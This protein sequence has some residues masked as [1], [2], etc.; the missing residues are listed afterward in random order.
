MFRTLRPD[1]IE[2]RIG[3]VHKNGITLLLYK[4]ARCDMAILD[5]NVGAGGWQ[6]QHKEIKGNVYCGVGLLNTACGGSPVVEW[7]WKWDVG[8]ESYTEKEKGEASDSFKRAC[9][10]WGIG[11]EL[12]TAPFISIKV[13]TEQYNNKYQLVNKKDGYGYKVKSIEYSDNKISYLEIEKN[14]QTVWSMER[15]P[16]ETITGKDWKTLLA[17]AESKG[18]DA[19]WILLGL[20]KQKPEEITLTDYTEVVKALSNEG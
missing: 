19:E 17:L 1:E 12:Y 3:T 4:D 13:P 14:G 7:I 5:E 6:R 15:V 8:T 11:R 20:G 16:D 18:R 9:V 10:N 2:V